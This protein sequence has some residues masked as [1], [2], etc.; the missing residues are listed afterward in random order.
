MPLLLFILLAVLSCQIE[1]VEPHASEDKSSLLKVTS[2]AVAQMSEEML[3][4]VKTVVKRGATSG[5]YD[6]LTALLKSGKTSGKAAARAFRLLVEH[7]IIKLDHTIKGLKRLPDTNPLAAKAN[8][9]ELEKL[10]EAIGTLTESADYY[11][12]AIKNLK[13]SGINTANLQ[14]KIKSSQLRRWKKTLKNDYPDQFEKLSSLQMGVDY[15]DDGLTA[16]ASALLPF[17]VAEFLAQEKS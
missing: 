10:T 9:L 3:P 17:S 1:Q 8:K 11:S 5:D 2:K 6:E 15:I 4:T 12:K 16:A 7:P 13:A 14:V